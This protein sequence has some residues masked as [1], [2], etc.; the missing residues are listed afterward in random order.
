MTDI[1]EENDGW[2]YTEDTLAML[3]VSVAQ[4][5][6]ILSDGGES[7]SEL[8][9]SFVQLAN[10]FQKLM[11]HETDIEHTDLAHIRHQIE[12]G[13]VAFQF[14]DRISQR[15]DHVSNSL[16]HMGNIIGDS[17]RRYNPDEW[18]AF[19]KVIREKYTMSSERKLFEAILGG[20]PIEQALADAKKASD[21][22]N[23]DDIEL[24]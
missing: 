16:Q 24:F 14:Y 21:N 3:S 1:N 13:I 5:K 10:T 8:T 9:E 18:E 7:V 15:L 4:I 17:E 11:D 6:S 23:T 20:V 12:Q 2:H 22:D 19:Q